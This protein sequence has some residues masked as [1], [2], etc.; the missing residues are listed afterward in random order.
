MILSKE[1][2]ERE[3]PKEELDKKTKTIAV[4]VSFEVTCDSSPYIFKENS[5]A[6]RI[7]EYIS[8][9][10]DAIDNSMRSWGDHIHCIDPVKVVIFD[11]NTEEEQDIT[12]EILGED[13]TV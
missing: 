13:E 1:E 5:I 2:L 6:K 10:T 8:D 9:C 3:Y 7:R 4:R 12:T 11:D